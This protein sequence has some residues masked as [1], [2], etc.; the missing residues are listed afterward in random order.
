MHL[1]ITYKSSVVIAN[2]KKVKKLIKEVTPGMNP[3]RPSCQIIDC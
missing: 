3:N 1:E 2:S